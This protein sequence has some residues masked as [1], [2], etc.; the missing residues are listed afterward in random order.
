MR[1]GR[2]SCL[3]FWGAEACCAGRVGPTTTKNDTKATRV[4]AWLLNRNWGMQSMNHGLDHHDP[5]LI[6]PNPWLQLLLGVH[7]PNLLAMLGSKLSRSSQHI[8]KLIRAPGFWSFGLFA[9][10]GPS[11]SR[12]LCQ[13]LPKVQSARNRGHCR[14]SCTVIQSDTEGTGKCGRTCLVA[15]VISLQRQWLNSTN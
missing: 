4:P 10:E 5:I 12:S 7:H 15:M 13:L 2:S 9:G 8:S 6:R 3:L 11:A 14:N 1:A